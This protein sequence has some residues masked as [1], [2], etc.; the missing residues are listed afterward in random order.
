[1]YGD[2]VTFTATVTPSGATGSVTFMDGAATI[3]SG[4]FNGAGVW[5]YSTTSLSAV[6]HSISAVYNGDST[7]A[8]STSNTVSQVVS[9]ANQATLTVTG[10]SSPASYSDTQTLGTSGGSG[11]GA[12]TFTS[13]PTGA[14]TVNEN[15][16]TII[17]PSGTCSVYA[18]KASDG[19][20]TSIQSD[21]VVLNLA[22]ADQATLA[23]T[24]PSTATFGAADAAFTT[25][26]GSGTGAITYDAGSSTACSIVSNQLHVTAGAGTCSITASKA[27]DANYNATSSVG[28]LVSV[29][30]G[31]QNVAF[32]SAPTGI[33]VGA[34]RQGCPRH[35]VVQS[36]RHVR[37]A[38][39][40]DLHG[41]LEYRCPDPA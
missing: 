19:N 37:L 27:G 40:G 41:Q 33:N 1:V 34:Y 18:T 31:S 3:G 9:Q 5:T 38:N 17:A 22:M 14:C 24:G 21:T 26:G 13:T 30:K 29:G 7:Y 20:Y 23:I 10:T 8:S 4:T 32:G 36:R 6:S 11:T 15:T 12:V 16:L 28:F 39:R 25:S 35:G 2:S